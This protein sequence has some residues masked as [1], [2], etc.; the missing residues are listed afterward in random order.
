MLLVALAAPRLRSG[1]FDIAYKVT[2][3]GMRWM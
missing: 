2:G 3:Y 1:R